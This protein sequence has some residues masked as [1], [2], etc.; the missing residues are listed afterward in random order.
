MTIVV[1]G[2]KW[3]SFE[4]FPITDDLKVER[5]LFFENIK[6]KEYYFYKNCD[7]TNPINPIITKLHGPYLIEDISFEDYSLIDEAKAKKLFFGVLG[8]PMFYE[9]QPFG[10]EFINEAFVHFS[11]NLEKSNII[12]WLNRKFT[13]K[14][15]YNSIYGF[16][17]EFIFVGEKDLKLITFGED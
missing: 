13:P 17:A 2:S 7:T 5:K 14:D 9:E 6:S 11:S 16:W 8:D 4:H 15:S 1:K 3:V 10:L 12:Y